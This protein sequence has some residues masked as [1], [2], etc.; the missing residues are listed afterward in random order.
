MEGDVELGTLEVHAWAL[1]AD[2]L[3][4]DHHH[5]NELVAA[6]QTQTFVLPVGLVEE[7]DVERERESSL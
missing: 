4:G 1:D 3:Q 5:A 2:L 7:D 6:L